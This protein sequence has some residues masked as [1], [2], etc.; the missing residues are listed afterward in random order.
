MRAHGGEEP[1]PETAAPPLKALG[2]GKRQ[3]GKYIESVGRRPGE[4]I[5]LQLKGRR[6][7]S[8]LESGPTASALCFNRFNRK[9]CYK[10]ETCTGVRVRTPPP[11]SC[12][13]L[14][15]PQFMDLFMLSSDTATLCYHFPCAVFFADAV[16]FTRTSDLH[17]GC[18]TLC[19]GKK[20]SPLE[21]RIFQKPPQFWRLVA[22]HPCLL[23]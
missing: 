18:V 10:T 15:F 14:I 5:K 3:G 7:R 6:N 20:S 11:R 22:S 16:L 4:H 1:P 8:G 9:A 13:G 23:M 21:L 19:G 17:G 12:S 2:V